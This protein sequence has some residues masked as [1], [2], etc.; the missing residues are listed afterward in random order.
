MCTSVC[1]CVCVFLCI[2]VY[3]WVYVCML[4][5]IYISLSLSLSLYIYVYLNICVCIYAYIYIYIHIYI[6]LY[7][8]YEYKFTY[9]YIHVYIVI[10]THVYTCKY[11]CGTSHHFFWKIAVS[12]VTVSENVSRLFKEHISTAF[13]EK[14]LQKVQIMNSWVRF[15]LILNAPIEFNSLILSKLSFHQSY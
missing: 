11:R 5:Y 8:L 6:R 10:H 14:S 9:V 2:H 1:L 12:S 7:T 3:A 15:C 4:I 13:R